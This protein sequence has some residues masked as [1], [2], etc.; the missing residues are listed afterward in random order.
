MCIRDRL[1]AVLSETPHPDWGD[2]F[3]LV[4]IEGSMLHETVFYHQASKTL[5]AADLIENFHQC[6]HGFTRWYLK[7]GG[8][9]KVPGW[10]PM[11]RLVYLNRRKARASVTR[12]LE[13]PFEKLSLAH[14]EV[15][16]DNARNQVRH[17]MEWLF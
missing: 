1:D 4:F 2:D 15:I 7:L 9:W 8:L 11:L 3:E 13:W 17:G 12:I 10:H 5:I 6:D 16:T 14:G